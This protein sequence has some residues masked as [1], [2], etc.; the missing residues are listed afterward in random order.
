[1][2]GA[3]PLTVPLSQRVV[4]GVGDMAV[5]NDG[6]SVLSTY[7]LGSCIGVVAFD[8]VANV[9]GMLHFM[10]PESGI[11]PDRAKKQPALFAD[12]GLA[13]FFR[14]LKG[15]SVETT[16]VQILVAGGAS[17]LGGPDPFK[18]GERNTRATLEFLSRNGYCCRHTLVG[19]GTNRNLHLDLA[20][21]S[22]TL[23]TPV[24]GGLYSL[25]P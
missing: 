14:A 7:A 18:I 9:G 3:A 10:L 11:A 15:L 19:G 25:A 21:G 17:V 5:S 4:I 24:D 2:A 22:V 8:P 23:T 13:L 20:A 6:Q 1:M 16:N 12:T